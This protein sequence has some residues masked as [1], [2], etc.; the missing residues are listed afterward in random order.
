MKKL[1]TALVL[2]V[3]FI[4]ANPAKAALTAEEVGVKIL[5]SVIGALAGKE[6][7][8]IFGAK[9]L[10]V[11]DID[12]T[13]TAHFDAYRLTDITT[14]VGGLK[15]QLAIYIPTASKEDRRE[16][17][18]NILSRTSDLEEAIKNN[19]NVKNF[20]VLLPDFIFTV[21]IRLA[22][23]QERNLNDPA[24]G[25]EHI[26]PGEAA[27]GLVNLKDFVYTKFEEPTTPNCIHK[28]PTQHFFTVTGDEIKNK[29]SSK[30]FSRLFGDEGLPFDITNQACMKNTLIFID[31]VTRA[32]KRVFKRSGQNKYYF[33]YNRNEDHPEHWLSRSYPTKEEAE[34][35]RAF[36]ALNTY[37]K[38]FAHPIT[39]ANSWKNLIDKHGTSGQKSDSSMMMRDLG[40]SK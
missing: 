4:Q 23:L 20:F 27:Y 5:V 1:V 39:V 12:R 7:E 13:L 26:A 11:E 8:S 2:C 37:N 3:F 32:Q 18:F 35:F 9:T 19:I 36:H 17:I 29:G 24:P 38:K 22:F 16:V 14:A 6:F 15:R 28:L 40:L 30:I 34:K 21:N 10:T 31:G 25:S 33:I